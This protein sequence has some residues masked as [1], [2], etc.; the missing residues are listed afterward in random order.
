MVA[1]RCLS[2]LRQVVLKSVSLG[3]VLDL[4]S[5]LFDCDMSVRRHVVINVWVITKASDTVCREMFVVYGVM[6]KPV[7]MTVI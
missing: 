4:L 6:V 1:R 5:V 3:V 2:S 7:R